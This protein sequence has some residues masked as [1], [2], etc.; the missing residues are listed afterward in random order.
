MGYAPTMSSSFLY[1]PHIRQTEGTVVT[2]DLL[3][4]RVVRPRGGG[5][6]AIPVSQLTAAT[7]LQAPDGA[8]P[9]GPCCVLAAAT[10]GM[11]ISVGAALTDGLAV[12]RQAWRYDDV[13]ADLGEAVLRSW[14]FTGET[15]RPHLSA[16]LREL[17]LPDEADRALNRSGGL[18]PGTMVFF[19]FPAEAGDSV[20]AERFEVVLELPDGRALDYACD[21]TPVG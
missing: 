6:A 5:Y 17:R 1:R 21:V 20:P 8:P 19:G 15:R 18:R 12:S 4:D 2:P 7:A 10:F 9:G 16:A 3:I 13:R 14:S 11:L